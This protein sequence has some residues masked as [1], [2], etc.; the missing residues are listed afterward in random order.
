MGETKKDTPLTIGTARLERALRRVNDLRR[1]AHD[2][3]ARSV[4]EAIV[5]ELFG[6]S[7][8][9]AVY[10]SLAPGEPNHDVVGAIDGEWV[11]GYVHGTLLDEGWAAGLGYPAMRWDP[12][13][14]PVPVHVLVAPDLP[15]H[16][17]RLDAFEGGAYVRVLVP[18]HDGDHPILVA[19]LYEARGPG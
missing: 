6:A 7:R 17:T 11:D 2:S 12:A 16:W 4:A 8:R 14:E 18:V 3:T 19:N 13:A 15:D 10:G 9:L 1:A 5:E